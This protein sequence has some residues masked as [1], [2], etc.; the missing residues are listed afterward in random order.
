MQT[1]LATVENPEILNRKETR[2][3]MDTGS[4]RKHITKEFTDKNVQFI[5]SETK[6]QKNNNIISQIKYQNSKRR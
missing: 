5:H 2:I 3:L 6:S 1:P 4:Q